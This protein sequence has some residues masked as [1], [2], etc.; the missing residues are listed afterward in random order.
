M[1][2]YVTNRRVKNAETMTTSST[3][4][5]TKLTAK[6]KY[7][8][9]SYRNHAAA[10]A[11]GGENRCSLPPNNLLLTQLYKWLLLLLHD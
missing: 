7:R 11:A 5:I 1:N 3:N 10:A 9:D 8:H 2:N 4:H 6:L